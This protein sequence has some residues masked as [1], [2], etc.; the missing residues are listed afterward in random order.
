MGEHLG[1]SVA[2]AVPGR[3]FV[4]EEVPVGNPVAEEALAGNLGYNFDDSQVVL[5]VDHTVLEVGIVVPVEVPIA[6]EA[7][8]GID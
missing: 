3:S 5:V 4:V 8:V 7:A 1:Y 6:E 2:E